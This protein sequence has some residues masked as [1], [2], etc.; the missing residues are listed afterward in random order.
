V[1]DD[2]LARA[3]RFLLEPGISTG[4][5]ELVAPAGFGLRAVRRHISVLALDP[6]KLIASGALHIK[7]FRGP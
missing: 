6:L 3:A 7:L 2:V 5:F 4:L 1:D